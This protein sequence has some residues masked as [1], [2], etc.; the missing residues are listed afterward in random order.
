MRVWFHPRFAGKVGFQLRARYSLFVG[1]KA[2]AEAEWLYDE[3]PARPPIHHSIAVEDYDDEE[4]TSATTLNVPNTT[5]SGSNT[6]AV[7][8]CSSGNGGGGPSVSSVTRDSETFTPIVDQVGIAFDNLFSVYM[9]RRIAPAAGGSPTAIV[10]SAGSTLAGGC[11]IMLSGVDQSTPVSDSDSDESP[12]GDTSCSLSVTSETGG[13]VIDSVGIYANPTCDASQTAVFE[14][15][16]TAGSQDWYESASYKAGA[17]SVTMQWTWSGTETWGMV[18]AAF[19][20]A[21]AAANIP[22]VMHHRQQQGES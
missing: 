6:L 20:P 3:R 18:V 22:E 5:P 21:A 17:A 1:M 19:K 14:Q 7:C 12:T 9:G 2:S 10:F 13:L 15:S 4:I 16:Q 8:A 11:V